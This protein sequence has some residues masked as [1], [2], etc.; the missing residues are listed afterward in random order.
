M[1]R[2]LPLVHPLFLERG[3]VHG[4][5]VRGAVGPSDLVLPR[6]VHG[7]TVAMVGARG[8]AVPVDA[9]AIIASSPDLA[10]GV[11]TADCV[12][13]LIA[14][15]AGRC[16]AAVHGGWRG[17]AK[18]V[19]SATV[20]RL[21]TLGVP[22]EALY[23]VIGPHIGPCCYEVDAPVV[24]AMRATFGQDVE[25]ALDPSVPERWKL[26]LGELV[27]LEL[28]G[29]GI[30]PAHVGELPNTCTYCGAGQFFSYRREGEAAGRLVHF[31]RTRC[32]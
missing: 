16:V 26:A 27:R 20:S 3:I 11:V 9:D 7:S 1:E 8:G 21:G 32:S 25:R 29:L 4:F 13:I 5:G 14:E 31:I 23:A 28:G 2:P 18:G 22:P 24:D 6:Q 15:E 17:L 30:P 19:V 12:P 10:V